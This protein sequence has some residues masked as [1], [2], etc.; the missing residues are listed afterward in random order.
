MSNADELI[1]FKK[2]LDDGIITQ[3]EFEKKKYEL[4]NKQETITANVNTNTKNNATT[5][6]TDSTIKHKKKSPIKYIIIG[7]SLFF[8]LGFISL[9][10]ANDENYEQMQNPIFNVNQ[11]YKDN[12][13]DTITPKELVAKKGQ[14]TSIEKWDYELNTTTSYPITTYIYSKDGEEYDFYKGK[15]SYILIQKEFSFKNKSLI[16]AMFG[17]S[18]TNAKKTVDNNSTLRYTNCG[19]VDF[20]VQGIENNTFSWVKIKLV[21]SPF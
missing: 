2:L 3:E 12:K 20:W 16:P 4:L 19:V 8:V 1:K 13:K 7:I 17:L 14:P 5:I 21:D 6:I 10:S 11:F 9:M 18:T 15:L